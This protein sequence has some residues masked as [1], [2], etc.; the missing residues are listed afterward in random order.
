MTSALEKNEAGMGWGRDGVGAA[1]LRRPEG[2]RKQ[3]QGG[4]VLQAEGTT[5]TK[6]RGRYLQVRLRG[7]RRGGQSR[8][9]ERTIHGV[10]G[11]RWNSG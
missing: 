1:V 11:G 7:T 9:G 5:R 2:G 4:G 6:G 10:G 8:K 3:G